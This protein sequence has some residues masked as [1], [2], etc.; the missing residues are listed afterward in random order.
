[1]SW[2]NGHVHIGCEHLRVLGHLSRRS[3]QRVCYTENDEKA[4]GNKRCVP[5]EH[6][7]FF[8]EEV[9]EKS[10]NHRLQA[11]AD[12][13]CLLSELFGIIHL[14]GWPK[15]EFFEILNKKNVVFLFWRKFSFFV[16][17]FYFLK[18]F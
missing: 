10:F 8:E 18:L 6:G 1:M 14:L 15:S 11:F 16:C 5:V 3:N 13:I 12:I 9:N 17:V 7:E 2:Q 4:E